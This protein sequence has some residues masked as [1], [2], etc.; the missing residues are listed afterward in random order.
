VAI[1]SAKLKKKR[2]GKENVLPRT[3]RQCSLERENG[4][5]EHDF[6]ELKRKMEGKRNL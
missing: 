4:V 5:G 6:M 3:R 2:M 1:P